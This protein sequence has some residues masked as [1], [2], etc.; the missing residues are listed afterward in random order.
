MPMIA[1]AAPLADSAAGVALLA[2]TSVLRADTSELGL[3]G[4]HRET[5]AMLAASGLLF[6]VASFRHGVLDVLPMARDLVFDGIAEGVIVLDERR[7]VVDFNRAACGFFPELSERAI[8]FSRNPRKA[9]PATAS[10]KSA[11][12]CNPLSNSTTSGGSGSRA[13]LAFRV[14]SNVQT[15]ATTPGMPSSHS[16]PPSRHLAG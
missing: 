5:E 16:A 7:R 12:V 14:G 4:E 1:P 3:A 8:G 11:A 13:A 15:T 9:A 10:A 2:Y 6:A